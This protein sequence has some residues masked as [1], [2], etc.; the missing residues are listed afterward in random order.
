[1]ATE[2]PLL[3][4][5]QCTA[6][7]NMAAGASLNGFNGSGQFLVM[8]LVT[9]GRTVTNAGA[10]TVLPVGILQN[11]PP[12]GFV[13]DIGFL[14]VTKMINGV[15]GAL[16]FGAALMTDGSGRVI[17][18][19]TAGTNYAV[20]YTLEAATAQNQVVTAVVMPASKSS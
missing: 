14:G 1:M 3:H 19:T 15:A 12:L 20:G 13:A 2:A 10:S 16:A 9:A 11:D 18:W 4:H 7:V 17:V 6:A 5:S 8:T